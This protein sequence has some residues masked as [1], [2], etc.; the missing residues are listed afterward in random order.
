[1]SMK[2]ITVLLDEKIIHLLKNKQAEM[3][4]KK[5]RAISTAGVIRSLLDDTFKEDVTINSELDSIF[6]RPNLDDTFKEDVTINSELDLI[7]S[8]PNY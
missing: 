1:M 5:N 3:I 7:F 2:R 6:S 4:L 8:R